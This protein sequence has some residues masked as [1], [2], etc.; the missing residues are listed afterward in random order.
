[1]I[2]PRPLP[3]MIYPNHWFT[4]QPRVTANTA[5]ITYMAG[6]TVKLRAWRQRVAAELAL[7]I[8]R[9]IDPR[10]SLDDNAY[11]SGRP[12]IDDLHITCSNCEN[13]GDDHF[14]YA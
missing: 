9:A 5:W 12:I 2:E 11:H 7:R 8:L 1:M 4:N 3:V 13:P 14:T 6:D 10:T